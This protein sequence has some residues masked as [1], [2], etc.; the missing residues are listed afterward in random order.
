MQGYSPKIPFL[1]DSIDGF[2]TNKTIL[3]TIKQDLKMLL[4]TNQGE[5]MMNPDYGVGL[6][7]ILFEQKTEQTFNSIKSRINNQIKQYMSFVN[8]EN[9]EIQEI[10]DSENAIYIKLYYNIP[11]LKT[12]DQL[13]L[14]LATN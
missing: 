2:S 12:I 7:K 13:E 9:L 1:K 14:F 5:R 6:K 10:P 11:S 8:I 3:E 4:L